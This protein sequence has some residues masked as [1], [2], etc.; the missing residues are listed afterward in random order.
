MEIKVV[1]L[2]KGDEIL[3]LGQSP[4]YVKILETPKH[5]TGTKKWKQNPNDILCETVRCHINVDIL[6]I[7]RNRWDWKTKSYIPKIEQIKTHILE[8]PVEGKGLIKKID[9]NYHRLWLVKK[10]Y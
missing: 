3:I 1:D 4:K 7:T 10:E 5:Y 8:T 6:P 2:E 9:L